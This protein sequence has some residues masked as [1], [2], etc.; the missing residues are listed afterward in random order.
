MA[1][2]IVS[3]KINQHDMFGGFFWVLD[4]LLRQFGILDIIAGTFESARYR[5]YTGH[6]VLNSDLRL[7]RLAEYP[8]IAIIKIK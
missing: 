1:A 3:G 8:E 6:A 4:Q 7:G 2:E 5:E